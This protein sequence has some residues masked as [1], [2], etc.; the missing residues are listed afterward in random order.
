M[1]LYDPN[2]LL[3]LLRR[4]GAALNAGLSESELYD[5]EARY[6][7]VFGP[8]QREMLSQAVPTGKNWPDWRHD[9]ERSIRERLDWPVQG[10]LFDV[11]NNG[12]WRLSWGQRPSDAAKAEGI[13]RQHLAHVPRL[14]PVY[15]HR[16]L[17]AGPC[18]PKLPVFSVHQ[19]DTIYYGVDLE[20]YLVREFSDPP[21]PPLEGSPRYVQFWSELA[22]GMDEQL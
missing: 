9:D 21:L 16:Y 13:A 10:V 11:A 20:D 4:S 7:F 19:T 12:F 17:P 18:E 15:S 1:F 3:S 14:L 5:V 8:D 6:A 2:R 22:E